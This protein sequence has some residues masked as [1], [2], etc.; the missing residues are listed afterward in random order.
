MLPTDSLFFFPPAVDDSQQGIKRF[1]EIL[2]MICPPADR[3]VGRW[4]D[5]TEGFEEETAAEE[6]RKSI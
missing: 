4:R 1:D 6:D 2:T 3:I 5:F